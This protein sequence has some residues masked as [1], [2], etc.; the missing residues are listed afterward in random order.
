M[1]SNQIG[2]ASDASSARAAVLSRAAVGRCVGCKRRTRR[3][4]VEM[5]EE[6][7]L[8][9]N[10]AL[11][12]AGAIALLAVGLTDQAHA[13]GVPA[14]TPIQ[15]TAQVSYTIG[16][17]TVTTPSNT[18]TVTVAEILDVVVTLQSPPV[19]VTPGATQQELVFR[20]TNTG[21]GPEAVR[22]TMLSNIPAGD[23]FDPIPAVPAIYFDTDNSG[24]LSPGDTPY[25]AGSGDP[26]LAP[27]A[28]VTVLVVN[29]IPAPLANG[30]RGRSQLTAVAVTGSGAPG[31]TFVGQG[32]NGTDAVVGTTGADGEA[33]G[34]YIVSDISVT[35]VKTQTV[36][37]P[38]GGTRPVPGARITYQVVVSATG[39]GTATNAAFTDNI[40]ANTSY[41]AGSLRLNAA[42]LTD[43]VDAD[44]GSFAAAPAPARVRVALGNLTQAAGPQTILFTVQI[45]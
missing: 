9:L 43:A 41:V 7:I 31:T 3:E 44:A 38:F 15:N 28:F 34:E 39:T 26:L 1:H 17:S 32:V 30:D 35:A 8:R 21:N 14:G 13:A 22:L 11:G 2:V 27:D 20:V 12:M 18:V 5:R 37:D 23:N 42:T 16:A 45:N 40:P 6:C 19:S 29:D 25:V 4:M 36:A 33:V 24:D 10:L